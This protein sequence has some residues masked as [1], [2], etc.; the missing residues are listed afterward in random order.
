MASAG[1]CI[2]LHDCYGHSD[3]ASQLVARANV[4]PPDCLTKLYPPAR[5][6]ALAQGCSN[7]GWQS[8]RM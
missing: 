1:I 7:Y 6:V 4:G 5:N 2:L 3:C 8:V